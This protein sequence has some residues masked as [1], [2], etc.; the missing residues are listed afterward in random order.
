MNYEIRTLKPGQA[1]STETRQADTLEEAKAIARDL[2]E[3]HGNTAPAW[4]GASNWH[5]DEEA[6]Y[7]TPVG[8]Y[9][10]TDDDGFGASA[11]IYE[12]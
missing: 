7:G 4:S 8:G 1:T 2:A 9:D 12:A 11:V 6:E 3:E 5:A 10:A